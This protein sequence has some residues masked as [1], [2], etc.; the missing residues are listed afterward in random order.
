MYEKSFLTG[1]I[2][3]S[4]EET[5][6]DHSLCPHRA[7]LELPEVSL[8]QQAKD[9]LKLICLQAQLGYVLLG[10]MGEKRLKKYGYPHQ[11]VSTFPNIQFIC[12]SPM[13][14]NDVKFN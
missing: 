13:Q 4:N 9:Q 5:G 12:F 2:R 6:I 3:P 14:L 10:L 1:L 8:C 7:V 11:S